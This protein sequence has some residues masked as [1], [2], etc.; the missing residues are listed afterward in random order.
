MGTNGTDVA[1]EDLDTAPA[2]NN[3]ASIFHAK[4]REGLLFPSSMFGVRCVSR[5]LLHFICASDC[6][7]IIPTGA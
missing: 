2:D 7:T 3:F 1:K 5:R 6:G 4:E